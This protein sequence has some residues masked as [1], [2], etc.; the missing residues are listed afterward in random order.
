MQS[1]KKPVELEGPLFCVGVGIEDKRPL[2]LPNGLPAGITKFLLLVLS[3]RSIQADDKFRKKKA[4]EKKANLKLWTFLIFGNKNYGGCQNMKNSPIWTG[5]MEAMRGKRT[6]QFFTLIWL[7]DYF[8]ISM[9]FLLGFPISQMQWLSPEKLS[10]F[11]GWE[12]FPDVDP[13]W[14]NKDNN[15]PALKLGTFFSPE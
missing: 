7:P 12:S 6:L 5:K 11:G 15:T 9:H 4:K 1:G 13:D 14:C 2:R 3:W 8:S 10:Q